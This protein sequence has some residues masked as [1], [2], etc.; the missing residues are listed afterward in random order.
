MS[1]TSASKGQGFSQT[2]CDSSRAGAGLGSSLDTCV[3]GKGKCDQ[4]TNA[5]GWANLGIIAVLI[6]FQNKKTF[7]HNVAQTIANMGLLG[8]RYLFN[9]P[10]FRLKPDF[11][12]NI[13]NIWLNVHEKYI[14][15]Y[16]PGERYTYQSDYEKAIAG[17]RTNNYCLA[18]TYMLV[19]EF[20]SR[21]YVFFD[22]QVEFLDGLT[23]QMIPG[24]KNGKSCMV[25]MFDKDSG[26][27]YIK[28][29]KFNELYAKYLKLDVPT[30]TDYVKGHYD[31]FSHWSVMK[32]SI[33]EQKYVLF[34]DT[35]IN[36]N[37][38]KAFN[39]NRFVK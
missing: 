15:N 8:L 1:D 29:D 4:A 19:F 28:E 7:N 34:F 39:P 22:Y 16:E 36:P 6:E 30:N 18:Y 25:P 14:A 26:K 10:G 17:R 23:T 31:D 21:I 11:S 2:A 24:M 33:T 13:Q 38:T 37:G 27:L 20:N 5:V 9:P 32:F 35:F 3:D 12:F